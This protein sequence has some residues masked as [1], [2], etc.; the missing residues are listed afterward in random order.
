MKLTNIRAVRRGSTDMMAADFR[1]A[2]GRVGCVEVLAAEYHAHGDVV[3][4][5]AAFA[6]SLGADRDGYRAPGHDRFAELR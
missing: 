5:Q 2:D 6:V 3:L 1:V 4:E